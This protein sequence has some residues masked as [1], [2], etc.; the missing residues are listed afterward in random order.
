MSNA[1]YFRWEAPAT[2]SDEGR[3]LLAEITADEYESANLISRK[4][5]SRDLDQLDV[6]RLRVMVQGVKEDR[7]PRPTGG[8]CF[9]CGCGVAAGGSECR[10]CHENVSPASYNRMVRRYH[11]SR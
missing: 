8:V 7:A 1:D 3:A 11:L 4:Y 9:Q 5:F 10:P 6:R 2:E